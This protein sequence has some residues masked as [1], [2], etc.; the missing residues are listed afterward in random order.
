MDKPVYFLKNKPLKYN[1]FTLNIFQQIIN[2]KTKCDK[3]DLVFSKNIEKYI[4]TFLIDDYLLI[5][6][7]DKIFPPFVS[8][9][10]LIYICNRIIECSEEKALLNNYK[11]TIYMNSLYCTA[12]LFVQVYNDNMNTLEKYNQKYYGVRDKI[13]LDKL[14]FNNIL[15]TQKEFNYAIRNKRDIIIGY[16]DDNNKYK[17]INLLYIIKYFYGSKWYKTHYYYYYCTFI[18][19]VK[20]DSEDD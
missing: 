15:L 16:R 17:C 20:S 1:L 5:Y 3:N 10:N 2:K 13:L 14:D 4:E 7:N 6:R 8:K 19:A 9:N 12:K 18:S 11:L